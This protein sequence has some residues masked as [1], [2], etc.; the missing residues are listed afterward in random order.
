MSDFTR[1][2]RGRG[3]LAPVSGWWRWPRRAAAL[4]P[5]DPI[6]RPGPARPDASGGAE[7]PERL[8]DGVLAPAAT[9]G[10]PGWRDPASPSPHRHRPGE[11][12]PIGPPGPGDNNDR[13]CYPARP[14]ARPGSRSGRLAGTRRR[15]ASAQGRRSRWPRALPATIAAGGDGAYSVSELQC[16][17]SRRAAG[18]SLRWARR[19]RKSPAPPVDP[20]LRPGGAPSWCW[21]AT[22][23]SGGSDRSCFRS[24]LAWRWRPICWAAAPFTARTCRCCARCWGPSPRRRAA[25][26]PA[27]RAVGG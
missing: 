3:A 19:R 13:Y 6:R 22:D 1:K 18:P 23:R 11:E 7:N 15:H 20:A 16:S 8:A 25:S 9:S 10:R 14:T 27:R 2:I 26:L 24:W 12:V 5:V 21:A 4:R 17:A